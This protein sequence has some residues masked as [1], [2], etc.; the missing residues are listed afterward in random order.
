V[1]VRTTFEAV[2]R[3]TTRNAISEFLLTVA[4]ANRDVLRSAPKERGKQV[5]MGAV[6]VS[7]AGL[8]A[9]SA[10]YALFLALHLPWPIAVVGGVVWGLVIL[11]LDRW[12]V[13]SS[14]RLKSKLGTLAMALPRVVLAVL[15]GAVVSTPLTLAVF[16][17]EIGTEVREMAAEQEDAFTR[18][19]DG[20]SRY[21]QLPALKEQIAL[22]QA[23]IAD[24]VTPADV[25]EDSEV[26]NLQ[27]RFADADER[28]QAAEVAFNQE[29]DGTGG[30][31]DRGFGP[32]TDARRAD[33]DRLRVERDALAQELDTL[34]AQVN[35]KLLDEEAQNTVN[36]KAD[37]EKLQGLV[38]DTEQKRASDI[39]K[40]EEAVGTSDGILARLT[41]LDRIQ[42]D[43]PSLATAHWMLF[44]FMTALECLPIL[45]KTMLAL[46][47]PSLYERLLKL[48]EE[49]VEERLKL[50]MQTEYEEAE[51]LAK[52][53]LAAA[54]ARAARTLEAE[55]RATVMVLD[56]Q[57]DVT[58]AGVER[59]RNEQLGV[60]AHRGGDTASAPM[61][62]SARAFYE[63][64]VGDRG[65]A[66][67]DD[68]MA[69]SRS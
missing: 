53:A 50:R 38:A 27:R 9:V 44:A 33:R 32:A 35:A 41:A 25:A 22:L 62:S 48:D 19:L 49:K 67:L 29:I 64:E 60:A 5:A 18:Q 20:D 1:T 10:S 24:G 68:G 54:E 56:A 28:Y 55:S 8:A 43:N 69:V 2:R 47:P 23:D 36:Q 63:A 34:K 66:E 12:L 17:A 45:F 16:S 6:L 61:D 57:L 31:G 4:G 3:L 11:N 52:S 26:T 51:V 13:V 15:I 7:T 21:E 46:A 40:H 65:P 59:W 30:T 37:L 42:E 39:S 58:R 14:P